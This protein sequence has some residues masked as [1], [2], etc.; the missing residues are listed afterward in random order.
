MG[1]SKIFVAFAGSEIIARGTLVDVVGRGK[2]VFDGGKDARIAFYDDATGRV[3]DVDLVGSED[4]VMAKLRTNPRMPTE[5]PGPAKQKGPGRPKLGVVSREVSLLP[6][7]WH[8]LSEQRGGA[9]AAI[10]RLVDTARKQNS[11]AEQRRRTIEAAHR[12][13][14]DVAGDLP[15][16][17]EATRMLFAEDLAGL[18]KQM[19][20]WPEG[21]RDQLGRYTG[22][23]GEIDSDGR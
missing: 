19:G 7:H 17:E 21:I 8:W 15:N 4:E 20:D 1:D 13:L 23:L 12:F 5:G 3:V 2:F 6:R 16:F 10:R 11:G 22:R 14:W 9:S 18:E